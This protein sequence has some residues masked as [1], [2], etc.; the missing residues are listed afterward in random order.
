VRSGQKPGTRETLVG[1]GTTRNH[2][3]RRDGHAGFIAPIVRD[4]RP[5]G[6]E[7]DDGASLVLRVQNL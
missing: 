5:D 6:H 4:V 3:A 7:S 2:V 1:W